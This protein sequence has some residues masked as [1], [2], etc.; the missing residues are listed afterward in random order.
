MVLLLVFLLSQLLAKTSFF[1]TA[2]TPLSQLSSATIHAITHQEICLLGLGV[3]DT[4]N[5][6]RRA[7]ENCIKGER[8]EMRVEWI[9][10]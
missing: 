2:A 8:Y 5:Y 10:V 1:A 3:G 6:G 7:I 4:L 9:K